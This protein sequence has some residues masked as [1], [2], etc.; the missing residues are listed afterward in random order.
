MW[1]KV[2]IGSIIL[3]LFVGCNNRFVLRKNKLTENY[4]E[5]VAYIKQQEDKVETYSIKYNGKFESNERSLNFRGILRILK[6][7]KIWISISPMGIEAARLLFT[8]ENIQF[9]NRQNK[10]YFITD[11]NYVKDKFNVDINY[12]FVEQVLTNRL[13]S[14]PDTMNTS[15]TKTNEG[16]FDIQINEQKDAIKRYVLNPEYQKLTHVI[17]NDLQQNAGLTIQFDDYVDVKSAVLPQEIKVN[18]QKDEKY[19]NLD[20]S[21]KKIVLNSSFKI[22]FRIPPKYEQIWP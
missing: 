21:Y 19:I 11:Y 18:V 6:G 5:L 17:F 2:L 4:D 22:L 16:M 20:L 7:E 8:P 13:M 1:S 14:I 15:V 3:F 12:E 10:T 9:I